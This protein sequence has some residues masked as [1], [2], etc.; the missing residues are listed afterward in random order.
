MPLGHSGHL[1][2]QMFINIVV[3]DWMFHENIVS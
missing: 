3:G 2:L 1:D